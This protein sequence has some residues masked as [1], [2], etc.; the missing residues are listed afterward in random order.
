VVSQTTIPNK[1]NWNYN[2][3]IIREVVLPRRSLRVM[4]VRRSL[5]VMRI[6]ERRGKIHTH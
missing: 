6:R 5:R 3:A 2:K 1:K 4:R